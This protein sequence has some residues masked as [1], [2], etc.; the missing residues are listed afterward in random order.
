MRVIFLLEEP[1][2]AN[3]L[4]SY[5]PRWN[6]GVDFI[7]VKHQGKSD[8]EK[9]IPRKLR[10]WRG[11]EDRFVVLRDNDG[12][13]C[14]RLKANLQRLCDQGGRPATLVRIA[15]QEL[16]AWYLGDLQA[17]GEL[18]GKPALAGEQAKAK[19]RD[20]DRMSSPSREL[21]KLVPEYRKLQ[22]SRELGEALNTNPDSNC[23]HSF[24]VFFQGLV[25]L[26]HQAS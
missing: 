12:G 2:A 16:E 19:F 15:C 13:D 21:A 1:S 4:E 3:F 11:L 10:A 26:L 14:R 20:P 22:G 17:V 24:R 8:L 9:S 6:P 23:S 7:C 18:Y 5:L 25:K